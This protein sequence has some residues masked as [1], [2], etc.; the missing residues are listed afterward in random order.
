MLPLCFIVWNGGLG[1]LFCQVKTPHRTGVRHYIC[2]ICTVSYM[3]GSKSHSF[4]NLLIRMLLLVYLVRTLHTYSSLLLICVS[5]SINDTCAINY[6]G[7][8]PR[9]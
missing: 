8:K 4:Y 6:P 1:Y 3:I 9:Q 7:T 2:T 5:T